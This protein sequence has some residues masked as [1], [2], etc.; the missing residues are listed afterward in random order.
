V[1]HGE[2]QPGRHAGS[3]SANFSGGFIKS[4]VCFTL[5]T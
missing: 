3:K 1:A 2:V 5:V 4:L